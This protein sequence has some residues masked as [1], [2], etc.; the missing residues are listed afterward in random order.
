MESDALNH[1]PLEND[2]RFQDIIAQAEREAELKLADTPQ[3]L[4]YCHLFWATQK[5]ILIEKYGIDWHTP[6]EMN[7][8]VL[9][10]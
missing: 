4:G 10:D 3:G 1:D 6:A 5:Q 2:P 9:F 8:D 7:P